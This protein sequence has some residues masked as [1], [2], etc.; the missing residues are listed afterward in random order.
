MEYKEISWFGDIIT[1][2][3]PSTSEKNNYNSNDIP[4]IKPDDLDKNDINYLNNNKFYVSNY[5]RNKLRL[6]PKGSVLCSCIG[7]IGKIGIATEESCCNQQINVIIPDK[8]KVYSEFLAYSLKYHHFL[9][10]FLYP[11]HNVP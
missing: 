2:S 8:N 3:T 5:C 11:Y 4:F 10:E 1:G 7:I 9:I 6:F